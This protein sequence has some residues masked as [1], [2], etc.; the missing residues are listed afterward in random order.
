ML[1][2]PP[3]PTFTTTRLG[4]VWPATGFRFDAVGRGTPFG[5]TVRKLRAVGSVTVTFRT[6]DDTPVAGTPPRPVTW[7]SMLVA[8]LSGA[9]PVRVSRSRAGVSGWNPAPTSGNGS[10]AS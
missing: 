4:S 8:A 9:A 1:T 2:F 10:W 3:S 5:H 6:T 7:R